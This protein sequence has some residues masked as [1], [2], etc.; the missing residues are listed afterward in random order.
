MQPQ[1]LDERTWILTF[2]PKKSGWF[3]A[4]IKGAVVGE[5][6]LALEPTTTQITSTSRSATPAF[7]TT[8]EWRLGQSIPVSIPGPP[9]M[10][11]RGAF[12]EPTESHYWKFQHY[13]VTR[14]K[15]YSDSGDPNRLSGPFLTSGEGPGRLNMSYVIRVERPDDG[16][17]IS[18]A[19][20][21]G[22]FNGQGV[23]PGQLNPHLVRTSLPGPLPGQ[24]TD[25]WT[26]QARVLNAFAGQ[27]GGNVLLRLGRGSEGP[28]RQQWEYDIYVFNE[29]SNQPVW[30]YEND[31]TSFQGGSDGAVGP[32]WS[33]PRPPRAIQIA[34]SAPE[35]PSPPRWSRAQPPWP[36]VSI[37]P[38]RAIHRRSRIGS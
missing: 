33:P 27:Q 3:Y 18:L 36:L 20:A 12:V 24:V 10:A 6:L 30:M 21:L 28:I 37:P 31:T 32:S 25:E 19:M 8:R 29:S 16:T 9:A 14:L 13:P 5:A 4:L 17:D 26:V 7:D 11:R 35:P 2:T 1:H 38:W 15:G 22:R 34:G 23:P